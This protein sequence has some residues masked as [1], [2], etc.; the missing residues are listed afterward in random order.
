MNDN[1]RRKIRN[2]DIKLITESANDNITSFK[3]KMKSQI[4]QDMKI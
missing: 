1:I 4:S 2:V 3:T